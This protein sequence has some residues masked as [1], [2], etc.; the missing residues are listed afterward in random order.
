[1]K[2]FLDEKSFKKLSEVNELVENEINYNP[3]FNGAQA[4]YFASEFNYIED[5]D[6]IDG[7]FLLGK[8]NNFLEQ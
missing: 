1:M 6:E 2:I 4:M 3:N 8:I 5:C 7:T